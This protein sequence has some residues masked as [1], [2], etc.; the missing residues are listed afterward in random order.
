[1]LN[2]DEILPALIAGKNVAADVAYLRERFEIE[3]EDL[4]DGLKIENLDEDDD[5]DLIAEAEQ[6]NE[7]IALLGEAEEALD[8]GDRAGAVNALRGLPGVR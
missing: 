5:A 8:R 2:A 7:I 3:L 1:M 6:L 4:T